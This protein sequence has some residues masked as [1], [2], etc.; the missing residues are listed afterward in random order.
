[1]SFPEI[2]SVS[3]LKRNGHLA[4]LIVE[5][6]IVSDTYFK[7]GIVSRIVSLLLKKYI[8]EATTALSGRV[9]NK[10]LSVTLDTSALF[11]GDT[12]SLHEK[13]TIENRI[14]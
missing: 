12:N 5:T 7:E 4:I 3:L 6:G 1:M 2:I 13:K 8:L 10:V 9:A 14:E 11:P